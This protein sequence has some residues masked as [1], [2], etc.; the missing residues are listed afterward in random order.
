[1]RSRLFP[2]VLLIASLV[3]LTVSAVA[4]EAATD[5]V[6]WQRLPSGLEFRVAKAPLEDWPL[7]IALV[8]FD[9][10]A[11]RL[12]VAAEQPQGALAADF[13]ER[14]AVLAAVNANFANGDGCAV[15]W[16]IADSEELGRLRRNLGGVLV[17]LADGTTTV[18]RSLHV[19][20]DPA[21]VDAVQAG[22]LLTMEGMATPSLRMG[23]ARRS[24]AGTDREGRVVLGVTSDPMHASELARF[25][26]RKESAGGAGLVTVLSFAEGQASQLF[27]REALSGDGDFSTTD[28]KP[29]PIFLVVEKR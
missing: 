14:Q 11:F 6:V 7:S 26:S 5:P 21:P 12:R 10:K 9:P 27:V 15:G 2:P 4:E 20:L 22:G 1:M 13:E 18:R 16:V 3:G 25:L 29:V 24:F 19:P 17:V 28:A 8:R 23:L